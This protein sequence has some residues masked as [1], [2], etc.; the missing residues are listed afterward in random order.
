MNELFIILGIV[1]FVVLFSISIYNS[2][3]ND[4]NT[5]KEG[6]SNV[7]AT[8]RQKNKLLP[9]LERMV[10]EY[11]DFESGVQE[12]ITKLRT[13]INDLDGSSIDGQ[14]LASTE[15]MTSQV[16]KSLQIAVEA[17]PDLKANTLY[18]SMMRELS[19]IQENVSASI[20]LFNNS[21]K[22]YNNGIEMFPNAL[23]NNLTL[24]KK[25]INE[26]SDKEAS[27]GFDYQPH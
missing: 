17:Y 7:L 16:M 25:R 19:E 22:E 5:V 1:V 18:T 8:E 13:A 6:W 21:V 24:K 2:I 4:Y 3:I 11:T 10:S 20:R 26:F 15:V 12:S 27:S 9:E 23:I 14:S